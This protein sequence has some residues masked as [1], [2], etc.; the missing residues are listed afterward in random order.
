MPGGDVAPL[1]AAADLQRAAVALV[2]LEEVV[3][4]QQLVGE[5]GVRDALIRAPM[6]GCTDSFAI[7]A[8]TEKCLPT[9]RRNSSSVELR[10][11]VVVVRQAAARPAVEVEEALELRAQR[12][13]PLG[14]DV[15]RVQRALGGLAARVADQPG[16]AADEGDRPVAGALEALQQPTAAGGYRRAGCRRSGRSRCRR[17][18]VPRAGKPPAP[19]KSVGIDDEFARGEIVPGRG[20]VAPLMLPGLSHS[21][22]GAA[23][24]ARG[25]DEPR[26][27]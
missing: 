20:V 15:V 27:L 4:L 3:G 16:A 19:R 21:R 6:R 1:V 12:S 25:P 23:G 14:D 26:P 7:M 9:S 8:L 13:S 17:C 24:N 2:Q 5:L 18:V 11:P 22:R 10:E